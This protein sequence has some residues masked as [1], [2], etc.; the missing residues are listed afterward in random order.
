[1]MATHSRSIRFLVSV[2][3]ALVLASACS[4]NASSPRGPS[5]DRNMIT[6][7]ELST[8][9]GL[10]AYEVV[11]RLRP[12]WLNARGGARSLGLRTEVVVFADNIRLGGVEVLRNL[13]ANTV[14]QM[15]YMD[16]TSA[17]NRL[18]GV[19]SGEHIAGAIVIY[20]NNSRP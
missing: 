20:R 19:G 16:A 2:V 13:P 10:S 9:N 7:E 11:Q 14:R 6:T 18:P 17:S 1:M 12:H 3:A 15:E 8:V 5:R 4:G